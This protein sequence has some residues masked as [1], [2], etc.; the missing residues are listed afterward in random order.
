[1][2]CAAY[3]RYGDE[4]YIAAAELAGECTWK[5][6]ILKKGNCLC[7]GIGG[8]AYCLM[9]LYRKTKNPKW[10][11]RALSFGSILANDEYQAIFAEVEDPLRISKGKGNFP[12][13]LMEGVA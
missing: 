2:L 5:K 9:T 10:K 11:Y 6:G 3:E 7:H 12:F 4:K 1:M 13:S 8:N